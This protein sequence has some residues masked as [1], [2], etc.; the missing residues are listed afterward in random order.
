M[1]FYI[2]KVHLKK[3]CLTIMITIIRDEFSQVVLFLNKTFY[4]K[5]PSNNAK[6]LLIALIKMVK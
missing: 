1:F 5:L 2:K 6:Q 3:Y 4:N